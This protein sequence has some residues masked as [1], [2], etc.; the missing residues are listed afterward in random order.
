MSFES[1]FITNQGP[2]TEEFFSSSSSVPAESITLSLEFAL[3][4]AH[5]GD[6]FRP[7][8]CHLQTDARGQT[9]RSKA[10]VWALGL[11]QGRLKKG[12]LSYELYHLPSA[13]CALSL[14]V[15]LKLFHLLSVHEDSCPRCQHRYMY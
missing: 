1:D 14:L 4:V 12:I 11:A 5:A 3:L 13:L 2:V 6:S 7:P 8:R 10:C 15:P 9:R